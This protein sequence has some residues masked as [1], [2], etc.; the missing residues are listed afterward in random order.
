M[1]QD[2]LNELNTISG[3]C[4]AIRQNLIDLGWYKKGEITVNATN[5][6]ANRKG[7]RITYSYVPLHIMA[8]KAK[9][10]GINCIL[11]EFPLN[12]TLKGVRSLVE[13]NSHD[14]EYWI[15][16][17]DSRIRDLRY[18]YLHFSACYGG[19]LEAHQP[20]F[21]WSGPPDGKI[22]YDAKLKGERQR[23]IFKG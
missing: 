20:R 12:D 15:T 21:Y 11:D 9:Q 6:V 16:N 4:H 10:N 14:A 7:I 2:Y 5:V 19:L 3:R 1:E 17:T 13:D 8:D 22:D 18:E 23:R